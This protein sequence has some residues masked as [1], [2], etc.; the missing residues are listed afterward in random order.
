ML[1]VQ[2]RQLHQHR[3]QLVP[4]AQR[5]IVGRQAGHILLQPSGD[6]GGEHVPNNPSLPIKRD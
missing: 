3:Q 6:M 2:D 5:P 4:A 1:Q